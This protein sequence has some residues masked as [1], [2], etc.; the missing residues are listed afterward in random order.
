MCEVELNTVFQV[1]DKTIPGSIAIWLTSDGYLSQGKLVNIVNNILNTSQAAKGN[2]LE[3][4][5]CSFVAVIV[6]STLE[7]SSYNGNDGLN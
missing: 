1:K 7:N 6:D 2:G 5:S 3:N 4:S